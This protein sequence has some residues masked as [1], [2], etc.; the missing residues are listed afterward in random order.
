MRRWFRCGGAAL[1]LLLS[2][3]ARLDVNDIGLH[4]NVVK[5]GQR[6]IDQGYVVDVNGLPGVW[7]AGHRTTHGAVFRNVPSIDI[8]DQVC[9][10][11]KCYRVV[12][13]I[14]V[15]RYITP[16]YFG[17]VVLQTSLPGDNVLLVICEP[18]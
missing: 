1:L 14:V 11:S 15:S 5:G 10:Y 3:C 9:V 8:G 18:V 12:N 17:T 13:K 6:E 16:R 4:E 7:L 2:A